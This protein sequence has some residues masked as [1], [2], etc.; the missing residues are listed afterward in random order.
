[1]NGE[2]EK[3]E[4]GEEEEYNERQKKQDLRGETLS[5]KKPCCS[6]W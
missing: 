3:V 4:D 2:E 6:V 1:M 5:P